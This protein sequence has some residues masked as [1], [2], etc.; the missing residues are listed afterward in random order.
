MVWRT[1]AGVQC[2]TSG[3]VCRSRC[4]GAIWV[5]GMDTSS[6]EDMDGA[7]ARSSPRPQQPGDTAGPGRRIGG[8]ACGERLPE[9]Y[10]AE[11]AVEGS[12]V[13]PPIQRRLQD[14]RQAEYSPMA[15]RA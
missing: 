2:T 15:R 3:W 11:V 12:V 4:P 1:G 10:V 8:S 14:G 5:G 9:R 6:V 7:E 13:G